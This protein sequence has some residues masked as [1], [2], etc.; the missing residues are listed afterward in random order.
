MGPEAW[1]C[2]YDTLTPIPRPSE[3]ACGRNVEELELWP[4]EVVV[5]WKQGLVVHAD[6]SLGGK[7]ADTKVE[8]RVSSLDFWGERDSTGTGAR[9]HSRYILA[10]N[11]CFACFLDVWV[12][13]T[14]EAMG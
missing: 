9:G 6:L 12:R 13:L 3:P 8:L 5:P 4:R 1:G 11:L 2:C 14:P 10:K 7:K